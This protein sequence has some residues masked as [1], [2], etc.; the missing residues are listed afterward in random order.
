V[1]S[2]IKSFNRKLKKMVKV[3]QHI[4]VLEIDNDRKHFTNHCLHLNGEWKEVLS[5][6]IVSHTYSILEQKIDP[7]IILNWKSDQNITVPLNQVN[8][9][10]R[11]S[12]RQRK[13]PSMKYDSIQFNSIQLIS[14]SMNPLQGI[15]HMDI[16]IVK[17]YYNRLYKQYIQLQNVIHLYKTSL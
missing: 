17:K 13:T 7:P 2:E 4:S 16:E 6:L 10:N 3:H 8:A 14:F 9:I 15:Y 5:K 1:N 11:T 12:T